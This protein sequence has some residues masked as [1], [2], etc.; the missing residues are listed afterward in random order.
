MSTNYCI[1]SNNKR[2]INCKSCKI[3]CKVWNKQTESASLGL[4]LHT[5][6]RMVQ[7]KPQ[8]RTQFLTCLH[9]DD[10]WC[11]RACPTGAMYTTPEGI[12]RVNAQHCVGCKGCIVACPW[13]IPR[14]QAKTHTVVKCDFCY[15]RLQAGLEPA[16]VTSCTAKALRFTNDPQLCSEI[17][18]LQAAARQ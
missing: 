11:V 1:V 16:C 9:C 3:Q 10:P 14:W 7:G 8:L 4:L 6:P 17:H 13:Q 5:G 12:V 15:E 2:C 18:A